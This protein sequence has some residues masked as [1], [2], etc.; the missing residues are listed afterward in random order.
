MRKVGFNH[1]RRCSWNS[2]ILYK[3]EGGAITSIVPALNALNRKSS[4]NF[5]ALK[6]AAG[7]RGRADLT[8]RAAFCFG[9]DA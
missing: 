2:T 8:Y 5:T 6:E 1:S 3:K 9:A 4:R 7:I